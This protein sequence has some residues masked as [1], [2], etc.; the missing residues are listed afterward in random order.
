VHDRLRAEWRGEGPKTRAHLDRDLRDD[1]GVRPWAFFIWSAKR[2]PPVRRATSRGLSESE[3]RRIESLAQGQTNPYAQSRSATQCFRERALEPALLERGTTRELTRPKFFVAWGLAHGALHVEA[4]RAV[5]GRRRGR[6][7]N[8]PQYEADAWTNAELG[9]GRGRE[10]RH[11]SPRPRCCAIS[12]VAEQPAAT[13]RLPSHR[14]SHRSVGPA[15]LRL[16][17]KT[18]ACG[19]YLSG[20]RV[21]K[22]ASTEGGHS[23]AIGE[24]LLVS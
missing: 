10:P 5:G 3:R 1:E 4:Q 6:T 9:T 23:R 20:R 13:A 11:P 15:R 24:I 7:E 16:A 14:F 8:R 18:V 12:L 19:L 21:P 2:A 22:P 17:P